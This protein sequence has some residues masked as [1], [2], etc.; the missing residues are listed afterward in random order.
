M[1]LIG[2][3]G[4][5]F[6][7][8]ESSSTPH[9]IILVFLTLVLAFFEVERSMKIE[10]LRIQMEVQT[11]QNSEMLMNLIRL[12]IIACVMLV[13]SIEFVILGY[14]I[15]SIITG[16]F[17][18]QRSNVYIKDNTIAG[19]RYVNVYLKKFKELLPNTVFYLFQSQ[20]SLAIITLMFSSSQIA[21]YGALSRF[22]MVFIALNAVT[23]NVFA[24]RFSKYTDL[25]ILRKR[26]LQLVIL[27][28]ATGF[29]IL[30]C[31]GTLSTQIL[32]ILGDKYSG[33]EKLFLYLVLGNIV[34]YLFGNINSLNN[35]RAWVYFNARLAIPVSIVALVLGALILDLTKVENVVIYSML[36]IL[37]TGFLKL[38]DSLRGL[39]I[40]F[41]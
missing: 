15:S 39:K 16:Y 2:S 35:S 3:V 40:I 8:K 24:P 21:D 22:G 13:I 10:V 31:V 5:I 29:F 30:L 14:I 12:G 27:F 7:Y 9:S 25:T 19:S 26:F 32:S 36:P 37:F 11:V 4:F 1:V 18:K 38:A 28:I 34:G 20:I 41:Y 33:L 23:T 6:Y 17:L